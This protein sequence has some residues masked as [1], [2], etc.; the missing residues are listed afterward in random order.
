M[1]DPD[2][3]RDPDDDSDLDAELDRDPNPSGDE[4][5]FTAGGR[6]WNAKVRVGA[7][8]ARQVGR[9]RYQQMRLIGAGEGTIRRWRDGGYLFWE[10]PRVYAVGHPGRTLVSDLAAAVLYAGPGAMLSHATAAWWYGLLKHPPPHGQIHV[11]T[12]RRVQDYGNIVVHRERDLDRMLRNGLPVTTPSQAMLDFAATGSTD[13]LRFVLANAD[14]EGL[15]DIDAIQALTGPGIAG[16]AAI[17]DALEIHLPELAQTRSRAER[18]LLIIGQRGGVPIPQTNVKVEGWLVDAFWPHAKLIVEIDGTRAHKTPAQV[19][20]DHQR[21]LELR[22][23]G[24][25]ILRYTET[26]LEQ[27][28]EAILTELRRYL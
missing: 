22:A 2:P 7:L 26:Q 23:A 10:L 6:R 15:L 11:S 19:R 18:L 1:V 8:A 13:H 27:Y 5:Q 17:N 24:Y 28:P 14:Y 3:D 4:S 12:P 21:D 25:I 9:V 16:S 20:R